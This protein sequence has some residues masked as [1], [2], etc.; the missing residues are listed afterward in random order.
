M[1]PPPPPMQLNPPPPPVL[2]RLGIFNFSVSIIACGPCCQ[3]PACV[4]L[5]GGRVVT[6]GQG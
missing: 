2:P 4:D 5:R 1:N 3:G 6:D